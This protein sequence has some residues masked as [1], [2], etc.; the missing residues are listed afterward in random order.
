MKQVH[1]LNGRFDA[2][3]LVQAAD[4][5][6][7]LLRQGRRGWVSTVNVS[8]LMLMRSN[9]RL[10]AF[11]DNS[12]LVVADGMPLVW[13]A[14]L[15]GRPL[16]ERVAGIDLIDELCERAS[17]EG[18]LVYLLGATGEIIAEA[19][20]R[21][22]DRHRNLRVAHAD[23]YFSAAEAPQ[24][25]DRVRESHADILLV[26]MGV[27]RQE[28]FIQEQWE[29]LGVGVAIGVGGSFDVIAGVRSRAPA[30]VQGIGMEWFYRLV[31]EPRRLF[32]RYLVS[33]TQFMAL[34]CVAAMKRIFARR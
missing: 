7:D 9:P 3:T 16:P 14:P 24:R 2:V 33:N 5:I 32:M 28:Y 23:G 8:I 17:R 12:A 13:F 25:A 29:R 6:F 10:Q 31:Q 30:W 34:V 11:V 21:L 27:P 15:I 26:G 18:R 1:F 19:A 22:G 4:T 20:R